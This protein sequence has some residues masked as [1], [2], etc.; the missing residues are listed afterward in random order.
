MGPILVDD[1]TGE[2]LMRQGNAEGDTHDATAH[3]EF[4]LGQQGQP[5]V[6]QRKAVEVHAVYNL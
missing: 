2:V 1:V 4:V 6:F 5:D 3:A